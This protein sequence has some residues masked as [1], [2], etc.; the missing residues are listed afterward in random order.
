MGLKD[1]WGPSGLLLTAEPV[2]PLCFGFRSAFLKEANKG[3]QGKAA[4]TASYFCLPGCPRE[5]VMSLPVRGCAAQYC[6][7]DSLYSF[8]VTT[9][10]SGRIDCSQQHTTWVCF[11]QHIICSAGDVVSPWETQPC[12]CWLAHL[13]ISCRTLCI[14]TWM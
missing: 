9:L 1:A 8:N 10:T 2:T 6:F 3:C 12:S 14:Q 5:S 11:H 7:S 4:G 13:S